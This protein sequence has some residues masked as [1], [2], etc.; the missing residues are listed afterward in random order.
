[1]N[2]HVITIF[3]NLFDSYLNDSIMKKALDKGSISVQFYNPRDVTKN[4]HKKVDDIPYGGGPGMVMMAEPIIDLWA[5]ITKKTLIE[6]LPLTK[7]RKF[8]TI[9]LSPGGEK[10]TTEYAKASAKEHTDIIF[11]CGRYEGI[12]ARVAEITGAD[13]VS[14]GDYVLTGGE[15]AAMVMIDSIS[16]QVDG[17]L[18]NK[19]SLEE[20]RISSHEMYTR[21][22][23]LK[24]KGKKYQVPEVLQSGNHK[25]I[26]EWRKHH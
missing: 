4:K 10:F 3:P 25:L 13:L 12:D 19:Q 23:E 11:I 1:M 6:K 24:Y 7:K 16:R 8:K 17:V 22:A 21:P 14:I 18:G 5:D 20:D 9:I 15:L 2:F 26:D